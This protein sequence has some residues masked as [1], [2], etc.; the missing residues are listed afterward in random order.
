MFIHTAI[1]IPLPPILPIQRPQN[2]ASSNRPL[3]TCCDWSGPQGNRWVECSIWWP[4]RR[5]QRTT[6]L[7]HS[8]RWASGLAK[9][10]SR[11]WLKAPPCQPCTW[12]T[13]EL[14][15]RPH[16]ST[17]Q[18]FALCFNFFSFDFLG[19]NKRGRE[20][21]GR[22]EEK[23]VS[24]YWKYLSEESSMGPTKRLKYLS[25]VNWKNVPNGWV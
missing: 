21:M 4:T 18:S 20:W 24:G 19:A 23:A 10:R 11:T 3:A 17:H 8:W 13:P 15:H 9:W 12:R 22:E 2:L 5:S 14:A 6:P 7:E 16:T 1:K 25:D